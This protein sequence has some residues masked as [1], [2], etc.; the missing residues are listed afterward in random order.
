MSRPF[1]PPQIP[2]WCSLG[3]LLAS[4]CVP[5]DETDLLRVHALAP[6]RL[7]VGST[8][9]V[10]GEGF[11]IGRDGTLRLDGECRAPGEPSRRVRLER[12]L[13]AVSESEATS[14][15]DAAWVRRVGGRATCRFG[16]TVR[17][18]GVSGDVVGHFGDATLDLMP[19]ARE[20]IARHLEDGE[21]GRHVA[22]RLG[23]TFA[24]ELP[25]P[26][27]LRVASVTA[28]SVAA[29]AGIVPG[30]TV[31][32]VDGIRL[33]DV[34]DLIPTPGF[35]RTSIEIR[36]EQSGRV[37]TLEAPTFVAA[38]DVPSA[39]VVGWAIV[40]AIAM[41][42]FSFFSTSARYVDWLAQKPPR[43]SE[44]TLYWLFGAHDAEAS[45]RARLISALVVALGIV[46]MSAAFAGV[47]VTGRLLENDFG[48]GI[49][50][51]ASLALRMAARAFGDDEDSEQSAYLPFFVASAPLTVAVAA[52]GVLVG[53][54]HLGELH[55]AQ[56]GLP[57]RWLVFAQPIAFALFPVFAATALTRVEPRGTKSALAKVAARAHLIVVSCLGAA[58]FL[59][60]WSS[61]IVGDGDNTFLGLLGFVIKAWCLLGLGLWARSVTSDAALNAWKWTVPVSVL[62]LLSA[63][64]WAYADLPASIERVSGLVLSCTS[65]LVLLYV[66]VARLRGPREPE[67]VVH[68]FL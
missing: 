52:I 63:I 20:R 30:D 3:L 14:T 22:S 61:P 36:R 64:V 42:I 12:P 37:D 62:G 9:E 41:L 6:D 47:A 59:G 50:L 24:D 58:L 23:L 34:A 65:A 43:D 31:L 28:S 48:I 18:E 11:P 67:L 29:R 51:T 1:V 40:A 16:G 15:V 27:G 10:E 26:Y 56:G 35:H 32:G 8:L 4:G 13:H 2:A 57:W 38:S 25:E 66:V 54:G 60:G 5:R 39:S 21:R 55:A 19:I 33:Y 45:R 49:L 46:G 53:T 17:F 7:S 68:P 44:A